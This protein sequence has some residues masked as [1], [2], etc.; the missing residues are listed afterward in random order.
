MEDEEASPVP[1]ADQTDKQ[2]AE[3]RSKARLKA[4]K[5]FTGTKQNAK[6]CKEEEEDEGEERA[7]EEDLK[8]DAQGAEAP[9]QEGQ[10]EMASDPEGTRNSQQEQPSKD[11]AQGKK[12]QLP[13]KSEPAKSVRGAGRNLRKVKSDSAERIRSFL[14]SVS[15][16]LSRKRSLQEPMQDPSHQGTLLQALCCCRKNFNLGILRQVDSKFLA[17]G[18]YFLGW[19]GYSD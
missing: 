1:A 12:D 15:N 2:P 5:W 18:N 11:E 9:V 7:D 10:E 3:S 17:G 19:L 13:K 4:Y 8:E 14:T 16:R 6:R